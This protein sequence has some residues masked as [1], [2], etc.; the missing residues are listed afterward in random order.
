MTDTCARR[1]CQK[2]E[3]DYSTGSVRHTPVKRDVEL[4][5]RCSVRFAEVP[6][7]RPILRR[8]VQERPTCTYATMQ[9][10]DLGVRRTVRSN[11]TWLNTV[12]HLSPPPQSPLCWRMHLPALSSTTL[13]SRQNM[14]RGSSCRSP[15]EGFWSDGFSGARG[16]QLLGS[17]PPTNNAGWPRSTATAAGRVTRSLNEGRTGAGLERLQGRH[18]PLAH[19]YA[20]NPSHPDP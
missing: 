8:T 5:K 17:T 18:T 2:A 1:P 12:R 11:R 10:P 13:L 19:R 15:V 16:E 4:E 9:Y 14:S 3:M 20:W 6:T 7:P